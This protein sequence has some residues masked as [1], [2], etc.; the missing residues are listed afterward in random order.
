MSDTGQGEFFR[1]E[2]PSF[3]PPDMRSDRI[4]VID[5]GSN[6]VRMVVYDGACRSPAQLFNE[7]VM[8]GLGADLGRT[9]RLPKDAV[10]RAMR[11]L[12]RFAALAPQLRVGAMAGVATAAVREAEDGQ[13][14][15]AQVAA[16]TG[17]RL[18]VI[19]GA[20]EAELAANGVLFGTPSTSG[21]VVDLG[22][23]SLEFCR[24][25]KGRPEAGLT[26]PLGPLRL[27]GRREPAEID[28][29]IRRY[30]DTLAE[31]YALDGG[32][33]HL[34]GGAFRALARAEMER[35]GYPL[36][37]LHE[38]RLP[39]DQALALGQWA[40][41]ASAAAL[42]DLA[43]VSASRRE[44][45]PFTG[46]L[47]AHLVRALKPGAVQVSAFG[48]REGLCLETMA[49]AL[50]GE[51]ALLAGA[52]EQERRRARAPGFGDELADWAVAFLAPRDPRDARLMRAAAILADVNWR[53]HPDY[54]AQNCWETVTR[55]TLSDLG[56]EGR[57]FIGAAL[58][59]RY[60]GTKRG[61]SPPP[62]LALL[63][64]RRQ[65][66]ATQLGLALRLGAT[67][68]GSAPGVLDY[69][70]LRRSGGRVRLALTGPAL[71]FGGE[72]V[73][74][75]LAALAKALGLG[76]SVEPD[77]APAG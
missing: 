55:T 10:E 30:L 40:S 59:A 8:C 43:S 53:T 42:A 20:E 54:R 17:I 46:R 45:L 38:Y 21:V 37:V 77:G 32:T 35:A 2:P 12:T 67:I 65:N 36:E 57:V 18:R 6:S 31:G 56:H 64:Q 14:F 44:N 41:R 66:E 4:G 1:G 50:R 73:E 75:R 69:A 70:R 61:G 27:G 28:R 62:A 34:V 63:G 60:K 39:A 26:T 52:R 13:A 72:E 29:D 19:S 15:C 25:A 3:A 33:L 47:L 48:L 74:K 5:V 9:G 71:P 23:A 7:K 24:I 11:A 58:V 16:R 49:P 22:G 68:A 76:W 51:D